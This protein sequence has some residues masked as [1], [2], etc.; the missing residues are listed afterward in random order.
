LVRFVRVAFL[1][2]LRAAHVCRATGLAAVLI[3]A[4]CSSDGSN[5]PPAGSGT[6]T[7]D[8]ANP[9]GDSTGDSGAGNEGAGDS[10]GSDA[11]ASPAGS[12]DSGSFDAN[13]EEVTAPF[14]D[15][16]QDAVSPADANQT[17][18]SSTSCETTCDAGYVCVED[19]EVGGNVPPNDAGVCGAGGVPAGGYCPVWAG[20][21]CVS[22]PSSC[23]GSTT[24]AACGCAASLCNLDALLLDPINGSPTCSAPSP[25]LMVCTVVME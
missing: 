15:A 25:T 16:A 8:A 19:R 5:G 13:R 14:A 6:E 10:G 18:I 12:V 23:T 21:H 1:M 9:K 20:Y 4:G 7:N 22:L 11:S 2:H 24:I 3:A 17:A